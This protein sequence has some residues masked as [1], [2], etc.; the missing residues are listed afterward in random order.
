MSRDSVA[1]VTSNPARASSR[2]SSSWLQ[3]GCPLLTSC[4]MRCWR[5]AFDMTPLAVNNYSLNLIFMPNGVNPIFRAGLLHNDGSFVRSR[6]GQ[7]GRRCGGIGNA[8]GPSGAQAD[9]QLSRYP[10]VTRDAE[11]AEILE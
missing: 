7:S 8:I 4:K 10:T 9:A 1:C 6:L 2:R 5:V 3:I 11:S